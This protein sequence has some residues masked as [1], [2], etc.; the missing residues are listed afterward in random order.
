MNVRAVFRGIATLPVL[1]T[2]G[3]LAAGS[4]Q[5]VDPLSVDVPAQVLALLE[6]RCSECHAP[7]S[8]EPKAKR[9]WDGAHDLAATREQLVEPGSPDLS[10]LWLVIDEDE[11]PP[12][13]SDAEPM[14]AEER[15]LIHDWI[16]SGAPLGELVAD[17]PDNATQSSLT[18]S[19]GLD[20]ETRSDRGASV[21]RWVGKLHPSIVHFPIALLLAAALAEVLVALGARGLQPAVRFCVILG[22]LGAAAAA[23]VGWLAGETASQTLEPQLTWHRWLGVGTAV[24]AL[25]LLVA[26]EARVRRGDAS[27]WTVRTRWLLLLAVVAVSVTGHLGGILVFG[28]DYLGLPW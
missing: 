7:D 16:A 21:R 8:E 6:F 1:A 17:A 10:D 24:L 22:F 25:A 15:T 14:T 12:P 2:L 3:P 23:S 19:P 4:P 13:D 26:S 11:M 9:D 20:E 27:P 18:I 5:D 28:A